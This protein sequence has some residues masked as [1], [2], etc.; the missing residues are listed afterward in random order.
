MA[1]I[2]HITL[3]NGDT[4]DIKDATIRDEVQF[5]IYD[6][7]TDLGLTDGS[8]TIAGAFAAMPL[9]S[10]LYAQGGEFASAEK[11]S[12]F[13][14]YIW[15]V[16]GVTV[17]RSSIEAKG[18]MASFGDWRMFLNSSG[19]PTGTWVPVT[20]QN[21][22]LF[23]VKSVTTQTVSIN[24]NS[25]AWVGATPPT[26]S[27]YKA[28]AVAGWQARATNVSISVYAVRF[29]TDGKVNVALHNLATSAQATGCYA[30]VDV[31][32]IRD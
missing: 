1:D 31:L 26:V 25:N 7:V 18:S 19:E 29:D 17:H 11:P 16:K 5:K 21:P 10:I 9:H 8:A 24:A 4:H 32:Y 2:K 27:G 23:L 15:I 13:Y 12:G 30:E 20:T 3:P 6:S 28:V 22:G 14:G